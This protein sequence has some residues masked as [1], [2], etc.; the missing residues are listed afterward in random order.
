MSQRIIVINPNSS[1][2]C[3]EGIDAA[4]DGLR[5]DGGPVIDCQ[6]MAEGP[7]GI[8]TQAHVDGI[9]EPLCRKIADQDSSADGFVIACFS[10]PGLHKAR[11]ITAKPVLGIAES[12]LLT[13][14]TLG[15]RFG[16]IAILEASLPRHLRFIRAMGVESRL[17]GERAVGLGVTE[18]EDEDRTLTR[19][20]ECGRQLKDEDGADV[21]IMGCAGMAR[22]R[23]R[24]EDTLGLPVIDPTQAAVGMAITAVRLGYASAR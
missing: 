24:L 23:E 13:A 20:I 19:M 16:I 4:L 9:V 5:L 14:L 8:E 2:A 21:L 1:V 10:D 22:Y 15:Q 18:L 12:G 17:A 7:P 6:T 3:T 11:K